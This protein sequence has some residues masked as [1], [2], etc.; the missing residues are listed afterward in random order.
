MLQEK[1]KTDPKDIKNL[2][3][4]AVTHLQK[5]DYNA[6]FS[7]FKKIYELDSELLES[8]LGM[9]LIWAKRGEYQR[10]IKFFLMAMD[11]KTTRSIELSIPIANVRENIL[12]NLGLCFLK[13]GER[14]KAIQIFKDMLR[15][16]SRFAPLIQEKLKEIGVVGTKRAG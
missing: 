16:N 2:H 12:Y 11:K 14:A 8:Y 15:L 13:T 5:S 3:D 7:Y 6:A 9:G 10:A 4:L 1:E